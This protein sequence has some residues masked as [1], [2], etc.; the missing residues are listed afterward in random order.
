MKNSDSQKLPSEKLPM[1]DLLEEDRYLDWFAHYGKTFL[2]TI[3]ALFAILLVIYKMSTGSHSQAE[4]D[5]LEAERAF[6]A[7]QQGEEP[8]DDLEQFT[9]KYPDLRSKYDALVAETLLTR[10]ETAE[11][12][13]LANGTLKRT[14]SSTSPFFHNYARTTLSIS[15]GKYAD[16]LEEAI[17]LKGHMLSATESD[18]IVDV[19]YIYNLLRIATLQR[20][21]GD[22]AAE[23]ETW[24]EWKQLAG[25]KVTEGKIDPNAF[26]IVLGFFEE[27]VTSL[28]D[29]IANR[30]R[31]LGK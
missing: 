1:G 19:L 25:G 24:K 6:M 21:L 27:N 15:E 18:Q 3:V 9:R 4:S 30:E 2:I 14:A 29:Y 31:E 11:A 16:A 22:T 23:L 7:F 5:Y 26:R 20:E 12:L 10:G 17:G 8:L 13:P 28:P